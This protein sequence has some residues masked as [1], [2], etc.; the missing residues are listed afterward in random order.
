MSVWIYKNYKKENKNTFEA[1]FDIFLLVS[2]PMKVSSQCSSI[3]QIDIFCN[4][5]SISIPNYTL[6][7][8][9]KQTCEIADFEH[10]YGKIHDN[11]YMFLL[12]NNYVFQLKI[13]KQDNMSEITSNFN[14]LCI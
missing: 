2:K 8:L 4:I 12:H 6:S 11:W 14:M 5:F 1:F 3:F 10:F 9:N 13:R 7:P